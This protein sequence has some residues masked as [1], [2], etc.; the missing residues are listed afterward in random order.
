[1]L[2]QDTINQLQQVFEKLDN[3]VELVLK[4]SSHEDAKDLEEMLSQVASSS[5]KITLTKDTTS[6]EAPEFYIKYNGKENGIKFL[7]I[8]GGHEFTSLILAILN[9]DLKGKLPDDLIINR[10][11][12]LKGPIKL[13][14]FVSLTCENCPDVV[15]ALNLMAA[16]HPDFEHQMVDGL[17]TQDEITRL[18]IQGVPSVILNDKL[19]HSGKISFADLLA[20]LEETFGSN[21]SANQEVQLEDV[22]VAVIGGGPAGA[23]AA[24][25]SVRKG[26]KTAIVAGKIGGQVND[27]KGIEN[28][29]STVY[30]EGPI[31]A[32]NLH[33]HLESYPVK[34]LEHR[35]VKEMSEVE[36]GFLLKFDSGESLKAGS[37]IIA[38]G[39]KWR[40]LNIPGEKEYIGRGVAFC[41]HCDGPFYKGKDV[42]VVG[43]GNS[44]VEAAIDLAGIVKSV[45]LFEFMPDLKAD[46]VLVEKLQSLPNVTIIKNARTAS[47][48]GDGAKVVGLEYED[49][50]TGELKTRELDAVFVQIGL[51]PNSSFAKGIVEMNKFGE[52]LVDSKNRTNVK[53]IFAAGD[54]T[55]TPYKQ[56]IIAMGE[57]AK[58]ALTC[59]EDKMF[60]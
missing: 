7:G 45:T 33:K 41:P 38:T 46:K 2:D 36:G 6:A 37:I 58:A 4:N 19:I 14:T 44:G 9:S 29:V 13:R 50:A 18:G 15:Q 32:A 24:I 35:S 47:V 60:K 12:R 59:F 21:E 11:K 39:A 1:M 53:G 31:L 8:P 10:I 23:S 54:V 26:Q 27:T 17:Y 42:A 20:K 55:N 22:D 48:V 40:E 5:S 57:G 43:G 51:V 56:I 52:I 34:I 28:F 16:I 25:Y 30:T 3:N 49:R